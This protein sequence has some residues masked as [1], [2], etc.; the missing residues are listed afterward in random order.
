[1][2]KKIK[3][4]HYVNNK[5]LVTAIC[6]WQ[7]NCK[8]A[9]KA[10]RERPR[11]NEYI[12]KCILLICNGLA[13]K[14]NFARFSYR[15]EFVSDGIEACCKAIKNFDITK[16]EKAFVYLTMV[17]FRAFQR[18][19]IDERKQ[20]A[21]KHKNFQHRNMIADLDGQIHENIDNEYSSRIIDEFET[22]HLLGKTPKPVKKGKVNFKGQK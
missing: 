10:K 6:L 12:G 17:A 5:D 16:T 4:I 15:D 3:V 1:M 21:I 9:D 19:I 18:R 20:H 2:V 13:S 7:Q 14:H 11:P 22:K 8:K